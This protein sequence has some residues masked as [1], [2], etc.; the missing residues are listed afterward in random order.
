MLRKGRF[1]VIDGKEYALLSSKGEYYL[2]SSNVLDLANGFCILGGYQDRFI[3]RVSFDK[4]ESAYEVFP[5]VMLKSHRFMVE[6]VNYQTDMITL[7]TSN[8]FVQKKM[9]ARPYRNNTFIVEYPLEEVKIE[10]EKIPIL[11]FESKQPYSTDLIR[12][13][14]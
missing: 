1:A 7:V 9:E 11:G 13:V 4:L 3:K 5:N 8:P 2:K 12:E 10:E 6:S 14:R